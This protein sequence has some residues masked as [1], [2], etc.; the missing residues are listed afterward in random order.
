MKAQDPDVKV[1]VFAIGARIS[2]LRRRRGWTQ[3]ETAERI[4]MHLAQYRHIEQGR[5]DILVGTLLKIARALDVPI[6]TLLRSPR[7]P[8]PRARVD[9]TLAR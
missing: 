8:R 6:A 2:E 5:R 1:L 7:T 9:V 3:R 4:P